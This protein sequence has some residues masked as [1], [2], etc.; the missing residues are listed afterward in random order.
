MI[1]DKDLLTRS[2]ENGKYFASKLNSLKN[3]HEIVKEVRG[4]G[5]MLG[6]E[7]EENCADMVNDMRERGVLIN[8]AADKVLRFVPPSLL[9]NTRL[10]LLLKISMRF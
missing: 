3:K 10:T 1:L 8:C 7:L 6:L 5:L 2:K 4:S 9:K